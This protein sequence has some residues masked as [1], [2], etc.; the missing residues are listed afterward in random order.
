MGRLLIGSIV[1][2][3]AI[4]RNASPCFFT[5][6]FIFYFF[7]STNKKSADKSIRK[8]FEIRN[9]RMNL[10]VSVFFI[11][12]QDFSLV[13]IFASFFF[14]SSSTASAI[15]SIS[16][17]LLFLSLFMDR[18]LVSAGEIFS[19]PFSS[20]VFLRRVVLLDGFS[21]LTIPFSTSFCFLAI[22]ALAFGFSFLV[23]VF[24]NGIQHGQWTCESDCALENK[25]P[26]DDPEDTDSRIDFW[27]D[28]RC[29]IRKHSSF[30]LF[31]TMFVFP[32]RH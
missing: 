24:S 10:L 14:S 8:K 25:A 26:C 27:I 2:A 5:P 12:S 19:S 4:M 20:T 32:G 17:F 21:L 29:R 6:C 7:I 23:A 13:I 3:A 11:L 18:T 28:N 15:T 16:V 31:Y 1:K 22:D 9:L 30:P